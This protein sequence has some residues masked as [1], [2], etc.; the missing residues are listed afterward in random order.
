VLAKPVLYR[1]HYFKQHRQEYHDRLQAVRDAGDWEG[2]L[3]FFLCGV[4]EVSTQATETAR[5]ILALREDHR[6][7]ITHGRGRAAGNGHRVLDHLYERPTVSVGEVRELTGTTYPA[8][9]QLVA[10]L[11]EE[12]VLSE[13]TGR[14]QHRRFRYDAYVRLFDGPPSG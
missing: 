11:V 4:A 2:W 1:S 5:R 12:G 14:R 8:A 9:N 13:F 7:R 10:K 3:T 6:L